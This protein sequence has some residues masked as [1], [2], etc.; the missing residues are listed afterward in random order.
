MDDVLVIEAERPLPWLRRSLFGMYRWA[1]NGAA[2]GMFIFI[3]VAVCLSSPGPTTLA[4]WTPLFVGLAL[5]I[6]GGVLRHLYIVRKLHALTLVNG[7]PVYTA[8]PE[9]IRCKFGENTTDLQ[10]SSIHSV[11]VA[12]R[13]LYVFTSRTAAW[14][15][16][17]GVHDEP[18]LALARGAGVRIRGA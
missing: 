1:S 4:T 7:V 15:I 18:L 16:P 13:T 6:I 12:P 9:R 17:R 3:M 11:C 5:A 8:T 10:W 14:F 2:F